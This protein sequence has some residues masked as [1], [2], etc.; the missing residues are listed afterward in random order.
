MD[1]IVRIDVSKETLSVYRL[2]DRSHCQFPNCATGRAKLLKWIKARSTALAVFEP[3]DAYHRQLE[4]L[5]SGKAVP[6]IK[7]NPKQAR[8][9]AQSRDK[10]ARTDRVDCGIPARLGFALQINHKPIQT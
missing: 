4:Q 9:F 8:R 10:L 5:P 6:F 1:L 3:T 2:A 7:A